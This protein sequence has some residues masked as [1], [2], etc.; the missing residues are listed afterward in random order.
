MKDC[1]TNILHIPNNSWRVYLWLVANEDFIL[2]G[3][4][5]VVNEKLQISPFRHLDEARSGPGGNPVLHILPLHD[6]DPLRTSRQS[7][8]FTCSAAQ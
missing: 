2:H 7:L 8:C 3:V 6:G 1:S 4:W 5:Y